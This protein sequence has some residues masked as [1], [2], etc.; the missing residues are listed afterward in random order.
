MPAKT[1]ATGVE[2]AARVAPRVVRHSVRAALRL[3]FARDSASG[4][5]VLA[6]SHQEPPLRVVRA[7]ET[8][9]GTA[10]VHLHN[11]SGGLLGGDRLNLEVHAN[12]GTNVQITTTG[13]TRIYRAHPD[14][15]PTTVRNEISV[16]RDA[17]LEYL[18]DAAIPFAGARFA[19]QT[20]IR[21]EQGAGLFWWE[22]LA[23]GREARGEVFEYESVEI[24]TDLVAADKRIALE[25][26]SLEPKQRCMSSPARMGAYRSWATLYVCRMGVAPGVWLELETEVRRIAGEFGGDREVLWGVSTLVAHGIAVRCLARN[27]RDILPGFQA[28]WMLAKSKL[29]G[30]RAVAPRK[31]N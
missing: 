20:S 12:V 2:G 8:G 21:M 1:E 6:A 28:I 15:E 31:V 5:T 10:L 27:A 24:K 4:Q 18:P 25:R 23:P 7:F 17:L 3:E 9:D 22:I 13:A 16:G 19:Q 14:A 30:R 11:V 29:Y 26:L